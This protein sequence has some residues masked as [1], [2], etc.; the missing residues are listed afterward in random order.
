[1]AGWS[2]FV[3]SN[4]SFDYKWFLAIDQGTKRGLLKKTEVKKK[5]SLLKSDSVNY[6]QKLTKVHIEQNVF[7][8]IYQ[9]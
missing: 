9:I 7:K 5:K 8:R 4:I 3:N 2:K 1:M 6:E